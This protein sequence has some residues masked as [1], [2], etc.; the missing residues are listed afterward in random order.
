MSY[1]CRALSTRILEGLSHAS[2]GGAPGGALSLC[3]S[4]VCTSWTAASADTMFH[5]PS[6]PNIRHLKGQKTHYNISILHNK[7]KWGKLRTDCNGCSTQLVYYT[8]PPNTVLSRKQFSKKKMVLLI[9]C[10]R[11]ILYYMHIVLARVR[12]YLNL[13]GSMDRTP[14][15]GSG[16]TTNS[17]VVAL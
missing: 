2:G 12:A 11:S 9:F 1:L 8:V 15:S 5:R 17:S 3:L 10:S 13:A 14:T 16:L 7:A 6:V 4:A